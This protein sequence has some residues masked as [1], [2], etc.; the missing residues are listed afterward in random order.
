MHHPTLN[1]S[2]GQGLVEQRADLLDRHEV[3]DP[4][5][6]GTEIH[7]DLRHVGSPRERAVGVSPVRILVP[8]EAGR[9]P[10]P[11]APDH[12]LPRVLPVPGRDGVL[13]AHAA[14]PFGRPDPL[15]QVVA[16]PLHH[17]PHDHGRSGSHGGPAVR[18]PGRVGLGHMHVLLAETQTV[19]GELREQG[20]RALAHLDAGGADLDGAVRPTRHMDLGGQ[21]YL[22][23]TGEPRAVV[24]RG[25]PNA[26][27]QVRMLLVEARVA[28]GLVPKARHLQ[29]PVQHGTAVRSVVDHL[30]GGCGLAVPNQVRPAQLNRVHSELVGHPVHV[31]FQGKQGLGSTEAPE[32]AERNGV[33]QHRPAVD[34]NVIAGVRPAGVDDR[35]AQHDRGEGHISPAVQE[36][37]NVLGQEPT[38][39]GDT[40]PNV[41]L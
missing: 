10:V 19:T 41:D 14:R 13:Q 4:R 18:D 17:V 21:P 32:C 30:P 11:C 9:L 2:P 34:A 8:F 3:R 35:P 36:H 20:Q 31:A 28:R 15:S 1:L 22:T 27:P 23:P 33:G 39:T 25:Q 7:F 40:G 26:S 29:R 37:G 38:V 16:R 5:A 24:E 6:E 12:C